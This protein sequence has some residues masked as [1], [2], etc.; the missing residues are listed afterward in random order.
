MISIKKKIFLFFLFFY[1]I[2]GSF[3][4]LNTGISFDEN[5]EELN[6]K[7]N[8]KVVTGLVDSIISEKEFDKKSFDQ[9]VKSYVGYGIGFQII[10]QPIQYFVKNLISNN[11]IDIYGSKLI[12]K[13]L[14]VFL[15]FLFRHI[16]LLDFKKIIDDENFYILGTV[17]YLTY[18]YLFGQSMFSPK[19][20]PFM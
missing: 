13:H 3:N 17:I 2:I 12:A 5:Y 20:I 4:S 8:V 16:L 15:F 1:L 6:W 7:F 19:D 11:E 9:E 18:P 10:S 14:V